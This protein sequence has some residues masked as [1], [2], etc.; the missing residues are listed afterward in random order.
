VNDAGTVVGWGTFPGTSSA[1]D[2]AYRWTAAGGAQVLFDSAGAVAMNRA[3][4]ITPDG[5]VIV[6]QQFGSPTT[7]GAATRWTPAGGFVRL[8]ST[9]PNFLSALGGVS[10]DGAV[11]AGEGGLPQVPVR[12]ASNAPQNL[13]SLPGTT[14]GIARGISA[15]G[16]TIVGD[17]NNGN[18]AF[19]WTAAGGM[20]EILALGTTG[21]SLDVRAVDLSDD[22]SVVVGVTPSPLGNQAFRWTSAGGTVGL[23]DLPG[24][25]FASAAGAVSGN[26]T[27]FGGAAETAAGTRAFVWDAV[28]GMRDFRQV[29]VVDYTIDPGPY[30]LLRIDGIS[31]DGRRFVGTAQ[32]WADN[33]FQPFAVTLDNYPAVPEPTSLAA[34]LLVT[35]ALLLRGRMGLRGPRR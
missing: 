2:K 17:C 19:R 23:G 16:T 30:N 6:G 24:G 11:L 29:L 27:I 35:T 21:G 9:N 32:S 31:P 20:Q 15:D 4:G 14:F 7:T 10:N 22:G 1:S 26:G 18:K 28:N 25:A 13:G 34:T 33:S 12:W 5:S 8:E 3:H